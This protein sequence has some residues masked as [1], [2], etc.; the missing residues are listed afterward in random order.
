[1]NVKHTCVALF[2]LLS[3]QAVAQ[4]V[5]SPYSIL[6]IGDIEQ[7]T[8]DRNSLSGSTAIG[9]RSSNTYNITNPAS[10]T[11][12]THNVMHF[13][14]NGRGR[15]SNFLLKPNT[16]RTDNAKDFS[17][18]HLAMAYNFRNNTAIAFGFKPYSSVNYQFT[19]TEY[20]L[21]N[22][23]QII[24]S[25]D[26]EGGINQVYASFAKTLGKHFS[27]GVTTSWLFGSMQRNENYYNAG[28]S[29]YLDNV[30]TT[31]INGGMINGGVQFFTNNS[32]RRWN[33]SIGL[34]AS[35]KTTLSGEVDT[36]VID[37]A[38]S[39]FK[40]VE[41][42]GK[43]KIPSNYGIG[44]TAYYKNSF[45]FSVDA[46]YQPWQ[47]QK[48]NYRQ[49]YTDDAYSVSAGIEKSFPY[50]LAPSFI[51]KTFIAAGVQYRSSYMSIYGQ[52]LND[53]SVT[54][55]G[56]FQTLKSLGIYA[57]IEVGTK[58]NINIGQ[59]NEN[60]LQ[61]NVGLSLKDLWFSSRKFKKYD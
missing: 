61:F 49:S 59:I 23:D 14:A 16:A 57:G 46:N 1:M 10:L 40:E 42:S 45:K 39:I 15:V 3:L 36:E 8:F 25:V 41:K 38:T 52:P 21:S 53:K 12:L 20:L 11:S 17:V 5:N 51:E 18:Q 55:G 47:Y 33:H 43:F 4:N 28:L 35:Y 56:G 29:L 50:K 60:Y 9:K 48:L 26:G 58:G 22:S 6:G 24:K 54:F 13:E 34:I 2:S 19:E 44:Y 30:Q 31:F 32:K 7:K 27:V 37:N